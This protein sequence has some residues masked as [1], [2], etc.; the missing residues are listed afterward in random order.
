MSSIY[1]YKSGFWVKGLSAGYI[2]RKALAFRLMAE[3][4][5][6]R[7]GRLDIVTYLEKEYQNFSVVEDSQM[8]GCFAKTL[9]DG[10]IILSNSTYEAA[11]EGNGHGRFTV[12]HEL[13][14]AM[15]HM[16]Q[17][18]FAMACDRR[19]PVYCNSE[20]QATEFATQCLMPDLLLGNWLRH[21]AE[22][23]SAVF[24]VSHECAALR[25]YKLKQKLI[26]LSP[27]A[28]ARSGL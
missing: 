20:W 24:G 22:D 3:P 14:H 19:T 2:S 28:F 15:L 9:T 17:I 7:H 10:H 26:K 25:L 21:S 6:N 13:G 16:G 12:A 18:G 4:Y 11:N 27:E 5:I 23:V 8:P 1:A